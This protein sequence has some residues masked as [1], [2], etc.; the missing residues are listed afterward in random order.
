MPWLKG[1]IFSSPT[2]TATGAIGRHVSDPN[3]LLPLAQIVADIMAEHG[4]S[5]ETVGL[6]G[7]STE[8]IYGEAF[9][10]LGIKA[11]DGHALMFEARMIKS[12]DEIECI[13]LPVLMLR[14]L[15]TLFKCHTSGIRECDIVGIG[16][17]VLYEK[18]ADKAWEFV[19]SSGKPH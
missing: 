11:V 12:Q 16:Q 2:H 15:F 13:R 17:K 1:R 14:L 9:K 7:C 19:C 8:F 3:K 10:K 6:D 5:Q 18:C 4:L